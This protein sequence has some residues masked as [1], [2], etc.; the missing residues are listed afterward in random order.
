MGERFIRLTAI[1][2][3]AES[4]IWVNLAY[5]TRISP[6]R[7]GNTKLRL[8]GAD[9]IIVK[10]PPEQIFGPTRSPGPAKRSASAVP[11]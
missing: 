8:L 3:R 4:P 5:V 6:L 11:E 7:E 2:N 1:S 9:D 10:E